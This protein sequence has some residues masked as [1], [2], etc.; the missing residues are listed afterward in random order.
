MSGVAQPALIRFDANGAIDTA[1][2]A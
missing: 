2:N 1:F